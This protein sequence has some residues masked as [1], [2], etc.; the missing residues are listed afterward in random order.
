MLRRRKQND[1]PSLPDAVSVPREELQSLKDFNAGRWA[2][3]DQVGPVSAATYNGIACPGCGRELMDTNPSVILC[4]NPPQKDVH[5]P[6]CRWR[7]QRL[8]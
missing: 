8:A 6:H 2:V 7:G 1:P 3:W 4:S 5:C